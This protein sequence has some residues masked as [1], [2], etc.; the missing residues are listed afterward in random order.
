[1]RSDVPEGVHGLPLE[2]ADILQLLALDQILHGFGSQLELYRF[3]GFSPHTFT[4]FQRVV[5]LGHHLDVLQRP[6]LNVHPLLLRLLDLAAAASAGEHQRHR[7]SPQVHTRARKNLLG[8]A[9]RVHGL[10]Q[11]EVR[12]I[13]YL[14][15][16]QAVSVNFVSH[17]GPILRVSFYTDRLLGG[18]HFPSARARLRERARRLNLAAAVQNAKTVAALTTGSLSRDSRAT[19][20]AV[21]QR[22]RTQYFPFRPGDTRWIFC[23]TTWQSQVLTRSE[24]VR[25]NRMPR[26][27]TVKLP[28]YFYLVDDPRVVDIDKQ[29]FLV[30]D[31][32]EYIIFAVLRQE[33]ENV[34]FRLCC[35][36]KFLFPITEVCCLHSKER[37]VV[38]RKYKK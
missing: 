37:P 26:N 7:Q 31:S 29:V 32:G 33:M 27:C 11:A 30:N 12:A 15:A 10:G 6:Q 9:T 21:E 5:R 14:R 18:A 1:M 24:L 3:R 8:H 36:S 35:V 22:R 4:V 2:L 34:C 20:N 13:R 23:C 17:G 25:N 28:L 19:A 16:R 38:W